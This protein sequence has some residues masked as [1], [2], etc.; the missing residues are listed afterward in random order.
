VILSDK[1]IE[2]DMFILYGIEIPRIK[3]IFR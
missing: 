2:N 1:L 3:E